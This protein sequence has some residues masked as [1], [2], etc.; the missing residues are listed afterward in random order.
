MADDLLKILMMGGQRSGKSSMLAGL[1]ETMVNG[2]VKQLITVNDTKSGTGHDLSRNIRDLKLRLLMTQDK[3]FLIDDEANKT[4]AFS[5]YTLEFAVPGTSSKMRMLFSDV[6]GEFYDKGHQLHDVEIS[7]R[8]REYDVFLVAIDTP[9][10]MEAVNPDNKLCNEPVNLSYNHVRDLEDFFTELD[11]KEGA[12]AKLVIFVPLKCEK[13]VREGKVESVVKRVEEVYG[14][15]IHNLSPYTNV[16]IDILP[17]QTVGNIV[18]AEQCRAMVC[19]SD[20]KQRRCSISADKR[21][22]RFEDGTVE[23]IDPS[24]HKF[25]MDNR[26]K[27]REGSTLLRPN[28]WFRTIGKEY[29]PH[30]CDQLAFYILQFYLAKVLFAKK[31]EEAHSFKHKFFKF[32]KIWGTV[33]AVLSGG[34]VLGILTYYTAKYLSRKFGTFTVDQMIA[35][36]DKIKAGGYIKSNCDGIKNIKPSKLYSL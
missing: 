1:V 27:I 4:N 34:A 33:I 8:I 31:V 5:D 23:P 9:F 26:A 10:L 7:K 36:V 13:W 17:I 21:H 25:D 29:A 30:N 35:L 28:S 15:I 14:R 11:D 32:L 20:G 2:P 18:F 19:N 6:N 22:V 24:R 12:D 3:Q 16:E